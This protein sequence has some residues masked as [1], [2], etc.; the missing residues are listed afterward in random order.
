MSDSARWLVLVYKVAREPSRLRATVWR[1]LKALGAVYLQGGVAA[2]PVS[3]E[4]ERAL[5]LLRN[6]IIE[7]GGTAQLIDGWALAGEV[8]L[9]EAFNAARDEEYTEIISRGRDFLT[10]IDTE[11]AARHFTYAE[12]EENDEDLTKLRGWLSKVTARDRLGASQRTAA[13]QAVA[14]AAAALDG[15][16]AQVYATETTDETEP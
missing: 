10:E 3:A 5:R 4:A 2:L 11:T 7:L 13:E 15:F 16:A 9:V 12:L 14:A 1:R 6:E 8:D